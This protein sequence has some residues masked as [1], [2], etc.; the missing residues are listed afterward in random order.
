[1]T[2]YSGFGP[3]ID[4]EKVTGG[5]GYGILSCCKHGCEGIKVY[6]EFGVSVDQLVGAQT[7]YVM[8]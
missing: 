2:W 8:E 4:L 6:L 5:T 7:G 3:S 1:M